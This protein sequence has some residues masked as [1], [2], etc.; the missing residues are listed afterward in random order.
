MA[1]A[2]GYLKRSYRLSYF[3]YSQGVPPWLTLKGI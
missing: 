1:D 3:S 2:E